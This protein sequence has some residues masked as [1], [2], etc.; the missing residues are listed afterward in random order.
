MFVCLISEWCGSLR[1]YVWENPG[2]FFMLHLSFSCKEFNV[3]AGRGV[4]G[5]PPV[6]VFIYDGEYS[7]TSGTTGVPHFT[8]N[9]IISSNMRKCHNKLLFWH[10]CMRC[11]LNFLSA[12]TPG[13]FMCCSGQISHLAASLV[14]LRWMHSALKK[15]MKFQLGPWLSFP[16]IHFQATKSDCNVLI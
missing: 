5:V 7:H 2:L 16:F 4:S 8:H 12:L 1:L 13:V 6:W 3:S 14:F 10:S 9:M 15:W 11:L